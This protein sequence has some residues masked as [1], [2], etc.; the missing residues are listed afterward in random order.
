MKKF[1]FI[2]AGKMAS[3]IVKG[4]LSKAISSNEISCTCGNDDTGK[5]LAEQTSI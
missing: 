4:L 3:A 5:I 2:G 1:G